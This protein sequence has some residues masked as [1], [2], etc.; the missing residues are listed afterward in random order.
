MRE[1]ICRRETSIKLQDPFDDRIT[2]E[3]RAIVSTFRYRSNEEYFDIAYEYDY[4]GDGAERLNPF[5]AHPEGGDDGVIVK[6]NRMTI[7]MVSHLLMQPDDLAPVTGLTRA[8]DYKRLIMLSL[9]LF[10]D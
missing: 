7:E 8:D 5:A 3:V 1:I 9:A 6:K 2:C 4:S 10:W